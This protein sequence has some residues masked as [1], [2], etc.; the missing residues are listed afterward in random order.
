MEALANRMARAVKIDLITGVETFRKKINPEKIYDAWLNRSYDNVMSHIPWQEHSA[1]LE[2][3]NTRLFDL[4]AEAASLGIEGLDKPI[5]DELRY[6]YKNPY[7]QRA[8]NKRTAEWNTNM[9]QDNIENIRNTIHSQFTDALTP[10]RMANEIKNHI[11]LNPRL[12][13]AQMNFVKGLQGK[14]LTEDRITELS[15]KNYDRLLDYRANMIARTE[16]M[17]MINHGQLAVWKE[18]QNQELIPKTST[19]VWEVDGNPCPDCEDMDGEEVPINDVWMTAN[20]PCDIPTD[21]HP[22]CEC[23]MTLNMEAGSDEEE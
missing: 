9:G 16:S 13:T 8:F 12:A 14:S 11:G 7:V 4:A 1:H 19:K 10:R 22:N 20:G 2:S 3:A 18:G 5:R 17:Q 21:I 23:L 6:D 15:N